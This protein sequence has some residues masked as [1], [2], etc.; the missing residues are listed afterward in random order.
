[1]LAQRI[2]P[3]TLNNIKKKKKRR[4]H[5]ELNQNSGEAITLIAVTERSET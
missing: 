4:S 1:M 3:N 5:R 2:Q